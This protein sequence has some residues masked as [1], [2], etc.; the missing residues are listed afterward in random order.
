MIL[1]V[2]Q[3]N[4]TNNKQRQSPASNGR[5]TKN[6]NYTTEIPKI[7]GFIKPRERATLRYTD[8][9]G[10][11][12]TTLAGN[13]YVFR[14]NSIFDPDLT[15]TGHQ[16]YGHDTLALIYNR[17][18]VLRC[19]WKITVPTQQSTFPINVVPSNGAITAVTTLA[20]YSASAEL[21]FADPKVLSFGGGPPL[22]FK[23][24]IYLPMLN[25]STLQEY[26]SDD[27]FQAVFGSNPT[28]VLNLNI[29]LYNPS[30]GTVV[31]YPTIEL[32]YELEIFDPIIQA[33]S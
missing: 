21:P 8:F 20:T 30:G 16:P 31:V 13:Q 4:Q 24:S 28:E 29:A 23:N 5:K 32:W 15:G 17:Y 18:R 19:S 6:N 25:G 26:L 9:L 33:Q 12:T 11:S 22:V 10:I 7:F 3:M 2:S 14:L 27:R 1:L